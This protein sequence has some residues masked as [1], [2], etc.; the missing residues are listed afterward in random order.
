MAQT[1]GEYGDGTNYV[2]S[3]VSD[4][5]IEGLSVVVAGRRQPP[6]FDDR[7]V[8]G[9]SMKEHFGGVAPLP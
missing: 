8:V 7:G 6:T 2:G 3:V 1:L 5:T 4:Q 9:F